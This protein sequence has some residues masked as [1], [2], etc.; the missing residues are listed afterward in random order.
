LVKA[1][2][3]ALYKAKRTGRNRA[4]M[5]DFNAMSGKVAFYRDMS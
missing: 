1:A 3:D 5:V 4:V 2:D